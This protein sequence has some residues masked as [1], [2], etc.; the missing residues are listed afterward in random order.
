MKIAILLADGFEETEAL[1]TVDI[2]RRAKLDVVTISIGKSNIVESSHS[3]RVIADKKIDE[4]D[5]NELEMLI[6]PGGYKGVENLRSSEEVIEIIK[7]L[8]GRN[9]FLAAICAGPIVLNEAGILEGK[10]V[11]SFPSQEFIESFDK[12]FYDNESLVV[13]DGNILTSRGPATTILFGLEI[14]KIFGKDVNELKKSLLYDSLAE[15]IKNNE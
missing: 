14:V 2:L 3:I 15:Y 11:T 8:N 12:S 9:K 4:I 10:R 5:K 7:Y 13:R 1:F 6:I